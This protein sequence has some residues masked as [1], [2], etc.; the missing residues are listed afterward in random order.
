MGVVGAERSIC[1]LSCSHVSSGETDE[2]T[3]G[4]DREE[5]LRGEEAHKGRGSEE[6]PAARVGTRR[7]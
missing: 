5:V 6:R 7:R 4:R 1:S 3:K 2:S